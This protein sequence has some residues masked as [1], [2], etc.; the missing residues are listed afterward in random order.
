M[1]YARRSKISKTLTRNHLLP[2][3]KKTL[4]LELVVR[5]AVI[6]GHMG[7]VT[8]GVTNVLSVNADIK[9]MPHLK[10][11]WEVLQMVCWELDNRE[12]QILGVVLLYNFVII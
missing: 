5:G 1:S 12:E 4:I 9:K 10:I 11:V 6:V 2:P 7:V 3:T 8:I